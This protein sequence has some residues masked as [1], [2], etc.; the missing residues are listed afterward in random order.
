MKWPHNSQLKMELLSFQSKS[1]FLLSEIVSYAEE[2]LLIL[3]ELISLLNTLSSMSLVN[4]SC[5]KAIYVI[6]SQ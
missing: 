6:I 2:K 3:K 1:S 4:I 5:I